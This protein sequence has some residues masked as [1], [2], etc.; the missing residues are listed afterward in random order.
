[1]LRWKPYWP[2]TPS[3][4]QEPHTLYQDPRR[5]CR[6]W[7]AARLQAPTARAPTTG[8]ERAKQRPSRQNAWG[9]RELPGLAAGEWEGV[10][11]VQSQAPG[12]N[13]RAGPRAGTAVGRLDNSH[14]A[15]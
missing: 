13:T 2:E 11:D 10:G 4:R 7:G 6:S 9:Q 12:E 3:L 5:C 8:A 14:Y 1:M 15:P